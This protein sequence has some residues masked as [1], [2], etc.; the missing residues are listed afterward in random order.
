M[1]RRCQTI[2]AAEN[3]VQ[4][5]IGIVGTRHVRHLKQIESSDLKFLKWAVLAVIVVAVVATAVYLRR[6]S[7]AR[8]IANSMLGE[9]DLVVTALSVD[10]LTT[11]RL[12]LAELVLESESGTR[13]EITGLSLPLTLQGEE[14]SKIAAQRVIVT[15][16]NDPAERS[17]LSASLQRVLDLPTTRPSLEVTVGRIFLPE[18]PEM[19]DV[20]WLTSENGQD[21]LFAV[22]VIDIAVGVK[23]RD[24]TNHRVSVRAT[25]DDGVEVL[26]AEAG[27]A[28]E[29]QR[30]GIN[31]VAMVRTFAWLPVSRSLDLLPAGLTDLRATLKGPIEITLD[32]EAPGHVSFEAQLTSGDEV[33]ASYET[34]SGQAAQMRADSLEQLSVEMDYPS[35][36]WIAHAGPINALVVI[37]EVR[38]IPVRI[39]DLDCRAGV[40]CS[41]DALV[42]ARDIAWNDYVIETAKLSLPVEIEIGA[43]THIEVSPTATGTFTGVRSSDL[44]AGSVR[45]TTFSGTGV[46]ITDD[47]FQCRIDELQLVVDEFTGVGQLRASIPITFT[48]LNVRD[49]AEAVDTKVS[50]S[51]AAAS[52]NDMALSL[53]GAAGTVSVTGDRLTASI[54]LA[55]PHDALSAKVE[56]IRD[57][58]S[59]KGSL[60]VNDARV[61]F[62]RANL[63]DFAPGWP[64]AWDVVDGTWNSELNVEWK[65]DGDG[66][67]YRGKMTH[68]MR[69]L[70]GKYNDVAF[71]GLT[72][73]LSATLD[74]VAGTDVSPS[75]IDVRLLDVG[76]PVE[77]IAADYTIDAEK[78]RLAVRNLSMNTLGGKIVAEPFQLSAT[79]EPNLVLLHAR[80]I[81]LQL[82]VELAEFEN[83]E[84]TG[85][86]SGVLPVTISGNNITIEDG[87]LESD[88]SG[89]VIRYHSGDA[90]LDA[91]ASESGINIVTRALSN[92]E[93][94]SLTSD[95]DFTK[96]GDLKLQMR[97]TGINP[98]MDATQPIILNLGVENNVP[99]LL[100]SLQAIRSIE[101]ILERRTAN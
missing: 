41:M 74:S 19:M 65:T 12:E 94:D 45:V 2:A 62:D 86:V 40:R 80:S 64:H 38:E 37:D 34:A 97:L 13:Y 53:P 90:P 42:D 1:Y 70:A 35:Y 22:D 71:V 101:D 39:S 27:L 8:D 48:D 9:Q 58:S 100:R 89:G 77:N 55:D 11:D 20:V 4:S 33:T 10:S 76:L 59:D 46:T 43:D 66:T 18:F 87:R 72:T 88:S 92:F 63:S 98:D 91:V 31:G 21:L 29:D 49:S 6:D 81:Q 78:Q 3:V 32:E 56:L 7:I 25:L 83:I 79:N 67:D 57:L 36:E 5:R 60:I 73:S 61:S 93:F 52:W 15:F 95:V 44:A 30:Y 26:S 75:S 96:A 24:E 16:D 17:P 23:R 51:G 14:V 69:A 99:Q 28:L 47:G 50:V 54:G 84:M 82:M 68:D 85:A